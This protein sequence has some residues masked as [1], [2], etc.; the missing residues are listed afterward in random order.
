MNH[1]WDPVSHHQN[2]V[3]NVHELPPLFSI[4]DAESAE[5]CQHK[6]RST[7]PDFGFISKIIVPYCSLRLISA[8]LF[9]QTDKLPL[10]AF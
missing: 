5:G 1:E 8:L 10:F 6:Y 2:K 4:I 3:S 7:Q 9:F